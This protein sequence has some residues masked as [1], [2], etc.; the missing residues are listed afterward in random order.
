MDGERVYMLHIFSRFLFIIG[1]VFLMHDASIAAPLQENPSQKKW[2]I[3]YI[4][5]SSYTDF[6]YILSA[7]VK[8]MAKLGI[9]ENGKIPAENSGTSKEIW[10]WLSANAGGKHVEFLADGFYSTQ[11]KSQALVNNKT[12][13][14][15]RIQK[16]NDIDMIF[17]FGTAAGIDMATDE[18]SI[19][20]LSMSVT[21]A[22]QAGIIKSTEDSGLDHVH[23]QVEIGRYERQLSIFHDIFKFKKLGVPVPNT[24]AGRASIAMPSIEKSA[25]ELGF[26]IVPCELDLSATDA[27]FFENLRA[28]LNTLSQTSDAIY[29]TTN[30]GMQ[31][32]KM[33]ELLAPIIQAGIPSFSQNGL[34]ETKLGVLLSI[35]QN[36]FD[37]EGIHGAETVGKIIAGAKPRDLDQVFEG[38]LGLA[39]NL[40]MAMLI[41]WN[42]PFEILAAVDTIYQEFYDIDAINN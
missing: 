1:I 14:L 9:I 27:V 11:G 39:I 25:K 20:T 18:H 38:P 26:E 2:R 28:C 23:G 31:W 29:L 10:E 13:I 16:S 21:D 42:P 34:V 7:T 37:N 3:I 8:H 24:K 12:A 5:G 15:E 30:P 36:S 4:E 40:K 33:P 35:A 19:P 6:P 22:V 17:A 41:G 32:D